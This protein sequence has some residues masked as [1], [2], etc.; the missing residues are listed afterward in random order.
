MKIKITD[1]VWDCPR[2][3][4]ETYPKTETLFV[5]RT[6]LREADVFKNEDEF[7]DRLGHFLQRML[8]NKFSQAM[9][10]FSWTLISG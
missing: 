7:E 10:T 1:I 3:L 8:I 4:I 5:T 9:K 2:Q 6:Q